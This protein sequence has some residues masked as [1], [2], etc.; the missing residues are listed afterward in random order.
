MCTIMSSFKV[1][2]CNDLNSNVYQNFDILENG[3][4]MKL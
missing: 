1:I 3:L 4:S 2:D